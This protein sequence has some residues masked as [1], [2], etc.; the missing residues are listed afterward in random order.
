M[1]ARWNLFLETQS[2]PHFHSWSLFIE[3][4]ILSAATSKAFS[5]MHSLCPIVTKAFIWDFDWSIQ[6]SFQIKSWNRGVYYTLYSRKCLLPF[7]WRS[8]DEETT[9]VIS[10]WVPPFTLVPLPCLLKPVPKRQDDCAEKIFRSDET[11]NLRQSVTAAAFNLQLNREKTIL[12]GFPDTSR[13]Y[14]CGWEVTQSKLCVA[15]S[16]F[17]LIRFINFCWLLKSE[18]S[19]TSPRTSAESHN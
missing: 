15:V 11:P 1:D 9:Q 3:L 13:G 18:T 5:P 4:W 6:C 10:K 16:F 12:R 2:T 17:A 14:H 19:M 8:T 7:S